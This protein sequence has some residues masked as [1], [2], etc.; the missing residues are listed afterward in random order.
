MDWGG[1]TK[2]C[3]KADVRVFHTKGDGVG[4]FWL[5]WR[6]IIRTSVKDGTMIFSAFLLSAHFMVALLRQQKLQRRERR[7]KKNSPAA[8]QRVSFQARWTLKS[9]HRDDDRL[10]QHNVF[11]GEVRESKALC[12]VWT[13]LWVP[14]PNPA[15]DSLR[16]RK[17]IY[18]ELLELMG[19]NTN[20]PKPL[21]VGRPC[22]RFFGGGGLDQVAAQV[23]LFKSKRNTDKYDLNGTSLQSFQFWL[24]SI[25]K[26]LAKKNNECAEQHGG[27]TKIRTL[28]S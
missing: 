5:W 12:R 23:L 14:N 26:T 17:K 18:Y 13:Q 20:I 24:P 7:K 4:V 3:S 28:W 22:G 8:A 6:T 9:G 2:G 25:L 16:P 21:L 27:L 10:P 11:W 19:W 1:K 15:N